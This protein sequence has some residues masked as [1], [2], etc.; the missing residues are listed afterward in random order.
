M[1]MLTI[2]IDDSGRGQEPGLVLTGYV[3]NSDQWRGFTR[4]WQDELNVPPSVAYFKMKEAASTTGQFA[5]HRPELI[6]YR[7]KKLV[8]VIETHVLLGI[9]SA[10][11]QRAFADVIIPKFQGE[12]DHPL[13][14]VIGNPYFFCFYD[15]MGLLHNFMWKSKIREPVEFVFDEQGKEGNNVA[16]FWEVHRD[17]APVDSVR[18]LLAR[19]PRF[20]NDEACP[21]LQAADLTAWHFHRH[22]KRLLSKRRPGQPRPA[23]DPIMARLVGVNRIMTLRGRRDLQ[24]YVEGYDRVLAQLRAART[25][26]QG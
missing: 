22:M 19:A 10:V 15:I 9:T 25:P 21:P 4:D 26:P 23:F 7:I 11:S 12:L 3:A 1:S 8:S 5:G 2:Y 14:S 24:Q 18:E 16:Q 13:A 6:A 17:T 20:E